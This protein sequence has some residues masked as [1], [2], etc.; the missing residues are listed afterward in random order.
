MTMALPVQIELIRARKIK[1]SPICLSTSPLSTRRRLSTLSPDSSLPRHQL[2]SSVSDL[3][4]FLA[5][6]SAQSDPENQ[7][8]EAIA[9]KTLTQVH[10]FISSQSDPRPYLISYNLTCRRRFLS[11]EEFQRGAWRWWR[12]LDQSNPWE[13]LKR[14]SLIGSL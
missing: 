14:W 3:I 12:A 10:H 5:S 2:E 6:I 13:D 9:F 7:D 8:S 4:D 1:V 11:L